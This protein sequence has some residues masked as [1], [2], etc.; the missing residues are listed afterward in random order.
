MPA[1][2]A[3]VSSMGETTRTTPSSMLT[4]MPRPPNLPCGVDLQF[5]E[6]FGVEEIGMRVEPMHHPDDRFLDE[7]V[8]G[9]GFDVV[10]L[11]LAEDRGQELEV[12]VRNRC[13]VFVLRN[14]REIEREQ[15][16]QK[17]A[18]PDQ[19]RLFPAIHHCKHPLAATLQNSSAFRL[20][21][22][23]EL[24]SKAPNPGLSLVSDAQLAAEFPDV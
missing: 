14:R 1:R 4:S 21:S 7:L 20:C 3:G 8:V 19:S 9:D 6:L 11:D 24:Q 23:G 2:N 10:A 15:N 12:F 18:Q 16:A 17:G 5:L 13:F 22:A